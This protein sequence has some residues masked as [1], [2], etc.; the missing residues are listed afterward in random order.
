MSPLLELV[1]LLVGRFAANKLAMSATA[2][3]LVTIAIMADVARAG[4]WVVM[5]LIAL[6]LWLSPGHHRSV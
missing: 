2:I 1:R 5:A 6:T 3:S 4:G